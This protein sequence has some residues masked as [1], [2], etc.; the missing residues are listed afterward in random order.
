MGHCVSLPLSLRVFVYYFLNPQQLED[1]TSFFDRV[2]VHLRIILAVWLALHCHLI[3]RACDLTSNY[4][5]C[6]LQLQKKKKISS[7][8]KLT[9]G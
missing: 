4:S 2:R 7:I 3:A 5:A 6:H 8:G 9:F 1:S